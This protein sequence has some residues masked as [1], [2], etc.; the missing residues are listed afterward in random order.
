MRQG[1]CLHE[2]FLDWQTRF[3]VHKKANLTADKHG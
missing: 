1:Y 2:N 3:A